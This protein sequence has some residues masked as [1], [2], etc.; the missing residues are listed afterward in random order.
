MTDTTSRKLTEPRWTHV[1]IPSTDLD[2]SITFY[3]E[4]TPLVLVAKN[5]DASGQSA[6]LSNQNQVETP[7]VLVLVQLNAEVGSHFGI[8]AG[9][10]HRT[11]GPFSHIGV[12]LPQHEDVDA[13]AEKA[14]EM[15]CL[16]WEPAQMAEHV[17]YICAV[18]DPDGNVIEFSHNQKVY[19]TIR[20]LWGEK[21]GATA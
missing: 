13:I 3:T 17:G 11:L 9:K 19:E 1:A 16:H 18:T 21:A 14:R 2:R 7:F 4:L 6:W 10:P 15:G 8:E 20:S 12:E 5:K